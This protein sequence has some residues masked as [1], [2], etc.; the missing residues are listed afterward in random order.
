MNVNFY[1]RKDSLRIAKK[2][3]N[4]LQQE[5][6]GVDD[7]EKDYIVEDWA[8]LIAKGLRRAFSKGYNC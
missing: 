8:I 3:A 1:V 4:S 6:V 2:I 5:W 7:D